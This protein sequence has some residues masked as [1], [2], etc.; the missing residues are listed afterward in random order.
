MVAPGLDKASTELY[1]ATLL[2]YTHDVYL[3]Y[4]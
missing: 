2:R 4:A 1:D 3:V